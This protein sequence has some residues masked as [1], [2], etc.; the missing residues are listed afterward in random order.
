MIMKNVRNFFVHRAKKKLSHSRV[1]ENEYFWWSKITHILI[2]K[3]MKKILSKIIFFFAIT[4]AQFYSWMYFNLYGPTYHVYKAVE[5]GHFIWKKKKNPLY[6][7]ITY[8][9]LL[10][11]THF[12]RQGQKIM[13]PGERSD[14]LEHFY[15]YVFYLYDILFKLWHDL[16]YTPKNGIPFLIFSII[17][18]FFGRKDQIF[19]FFPK[20]SLCFEMHW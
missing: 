7:K 20:K 3:K 17:V 5:L 6:G 13:P 10:L 8:V 2:Q 15:V 1:L 12:R 19:F 16:E 9:H 11:W 14:I 18:I 4:H